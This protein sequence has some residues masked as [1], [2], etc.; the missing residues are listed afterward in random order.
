[1]LYFVLDESVI[2]EKGSDVKL[3]EDPKGFPPK[4]SVPLPLL[5]KGSLEAKGSLDG[6]I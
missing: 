2:E 3:V 1:M 5:P 4:R 6:V